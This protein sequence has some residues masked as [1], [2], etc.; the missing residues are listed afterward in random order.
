MKVTALVLNGQGEPHYRQEAHYNVEGMIKAA[1]TR[2]AVVREAGANKMVNI[3]TY[4]GKEY[5]NAVNTGE[6]DD[7][8]KALANLTLMLWL[9]E[10]VCAGMDIETIC[11]HDFDVTIADNGAVKFTR[12]PAG[13]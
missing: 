7:M 3:I 8:D 13:E 11:G 2:E 6:Y 1:E 9:F 5:V 12:I 10:T 4:S